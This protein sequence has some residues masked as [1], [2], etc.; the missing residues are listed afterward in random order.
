[1]RLILADHDLCFRF[2]FVLLFL[3][4]AAVFSTRHFDSSI[5]LREYSQRDATIC[6]SAVN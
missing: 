6:L 3:L 1:M 2:A 4:T 5:P